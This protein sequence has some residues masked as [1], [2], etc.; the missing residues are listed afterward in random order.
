MI[1]LRSFLMVR[2]FAEA[3]GQ[4]TY[5]RWQVAETLDEMYP[6]DPDPQTEGW[7]VVTVDPRAYNLLDELW[8]TNSEPRTLLNDAYY[9]HLEFLRARTKA[10]PFVRSR[11]WEI[12]EDALLEGYGSSVFRDRSAESE[13]A[14]DAEVM[15]RFS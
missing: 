1:P 12:Y 14:F 5:G 13:K 2:E 4:L 10:E 15:N 11:V 3:V 7:A 8:S 6:Y 9:S